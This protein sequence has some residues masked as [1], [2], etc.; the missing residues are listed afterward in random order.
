MIRFA[1]IAAVI[2]LWAFPAHAQTTDM[3]VMGSSAASSVE[4]QQVPADEK[5][6]TTILSIGDAIGGGLGHR[7]RHLDLHRGRRLWG[8]H[9]QRI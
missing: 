6:M 7:R 1:A 8:R 2:S 5:T 4:D 9:G 3:P